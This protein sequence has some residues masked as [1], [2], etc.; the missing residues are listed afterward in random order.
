MRMPN[1]WKTASAPNSIQRE[2]RQECLFRLES[3]LM[4]ASKRLPGFICAA[5]LCW[6]GVMSASAQW[7][8]YELKLEEEPDSV[9]F[10]FYT[11]AYLIA[12][13]QGGAATLVLT[14]EEGGNFYA[15]SEA[16]GK[17]FVAAN[18][19]K[20]KAVFSAFA[21]RGSAQAFYSASGY[22]NRSL[23]L[24]SPTGVRSWRVAEF[25]EGQLMATDDE[26]GLPPAPDGSFGMIGN[27]K[28]RGAL[29][30]DLTANATLNYTTLTGATTYIIE[31]LEKY[32]YN[33]DTGEVP[34]E[35]EMEAE[36]QAVM[37]EEE[38]TLI[39]PSLFPNAVRGQ[40]PQS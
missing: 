10:S 31:L 6:F 40:G 36:P 33:P 7:L 26:G 17:F 3:A 9:N 16:G 27:A 37:P 8:V 29:R 13:A 21:L 5:V 11:G 38:D 14:T 39:D 25:I 32:G 23:L 28:I 30:E 35:A 20:R 15:V 24:D 12:S 4:P 2:A 22:L 18:Q 34:V 1:L 19:Q